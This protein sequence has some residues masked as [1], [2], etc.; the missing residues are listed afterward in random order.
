L[1]F[2]R[3]CIA[4]LIR[5]TACTVRAVGGVDF[6]QPQRPADRKDKRAR[7]VGIFVGRNVFTPHFYHLL[8]D[9]YGSNLS[10]FL[11]PILDIHNWRKTASGSFRR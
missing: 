9:H 10:P 11:A 2:N 6:N 5:A 4:S 8:P 1:S 7:R 3:G